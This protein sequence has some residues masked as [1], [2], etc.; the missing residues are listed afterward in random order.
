MTA[1]YFEE[2][3][4]D[5]QALVDVVGRRVLDVGCGAGALGAALKSSG[6]AYVAGV[7][8]NETA[9]QRAAR[10]LDS[11]V[12]GDILSAALPFD[13]GSFDV[14]VFADV[15]EHTPN[16][17]EV[18]QRALPYLRQGGQVI[19]SVPNVRFWLVLLRLVTDRWEYTDHGVRDRTHLRLFSRRLLLTLV[20]GAGL[21][22]VRLA[23]NPRL[24]DDQSQIGRAGALATRVV[25]ATI[26]RL[27][28]LRDLFAY[29][30][31]VVARRS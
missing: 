20:A 24:L 18:V 31:V 12:T 17:E 30:Y 27:P 23:R 10:R 28:V 15:L 5:I 9:A 4:Q 11:V 21:T 6:A 3:R 16:P 19:I 13:H 25:S 2:P 22:P 7:E 26:A 1:N 29:Q 14:I 8:L